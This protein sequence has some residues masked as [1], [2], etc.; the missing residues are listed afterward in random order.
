MT[1]CEY[2]CMC[3]YIFE[4]SYV[5]QMI[6]KASVASA[7][8]FTI[9][10]IS[11]LLVLYVWYVQY[12]KIQVFRFPII[13]LFCPHRHDS[14]IGTVPQRTSHVARNTIRL[15][16]KIRMPSTESEG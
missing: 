6:P 7:S 10:L 1:I 14:S 11:Y 13:F 3:V 8:P 2:I 9:T 15:D 16:K 5:I 4:N 12:L